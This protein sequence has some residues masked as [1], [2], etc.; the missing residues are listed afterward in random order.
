[1]S[2]RIPFSQARARLAEIWDEVESCREPAILERRGHAA[3]A[4]LPADELANLQQTVYL[5]R[6]PKNA[7]RLLSALHRS[8]QGRAAVDLD[9]LAAELGLPHPPD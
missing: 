3:M 4:L 2:A 8:R 7:A 9:S 1:M 6:S 5:L